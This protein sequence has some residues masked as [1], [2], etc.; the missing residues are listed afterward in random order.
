[1]QQAITFDKVLFESP[2]I[3]IYTLILQSV[4][5]IIAFGISEPVL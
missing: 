5:S 3:H 1:M 4:V 2:A